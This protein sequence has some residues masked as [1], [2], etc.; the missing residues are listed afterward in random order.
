MK[1]IAF[2]SRLGMVMGILA[3]GSLLASELV[4]YKA[5]GIQL[6]PGQTINTTQPLTLTAGQR[7]TL[8]SSNGTAIN[9][10]GPFQGLPISKTQASTDTGVVNTLKMLV[11]AP[12]TRSG[13]LGTTRAIPQIL[14]VTRSGHYCLNE[15]Q[16]LVFW[17]PS[18]QEN[19]L[20]TVRL[21]Q[22][23]WKAHS[24]WP[25]GTN[26]LTP[27]PTM[28]ISDGAVYRLELDGQPSTTTLH[29]I[30]S[31]LTTPKERTAWMTAKGCDAQLASLNHLQATQ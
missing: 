13:G 19:A 11:S 23:Q 27:P 26:Q 7:V 21:G 12:K 9:L 2:W 30:P 16:P 8:L 14:D 4:V 6:T 25:A 28:P 20:I 15:G 22:Q 10:E 3:S 1:R 5:E 17:R 31:N 24:Q 18:S 29:L